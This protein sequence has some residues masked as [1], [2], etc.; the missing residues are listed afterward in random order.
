MRREAPRAVGVDASRK[1]P[2]ATIL[3]MPERA[4][5][6]DQ[7]LVDCDGRGVGKTLIN[8]SPPLDADGRFEES[9]SPPVSLKVCRT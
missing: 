8:R 6:F 7:A 1:V 9:M 4:P 5:R 2:S 3:L